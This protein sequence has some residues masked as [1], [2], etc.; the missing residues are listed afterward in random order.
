VAVVHPVE[1]VDAAD[2]NAEQWTEYRV[3]QSLL[4]D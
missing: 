2:G 3:T 4:V 1:L